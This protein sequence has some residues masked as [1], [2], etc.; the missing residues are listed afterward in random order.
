[1]CSPLLHGAGLTLCVHASRLLN[2]PATAGTMLPLEVDISSSAVTAP[3]TAE[4]CPT[5]VTAPN[6]TSTATT[7]AAIATPISAESS[8]RPGWLA[9]L[10]AHDFTATIHL[11]GI[12][13]S[14]G[15]PDPD[16]LAGCGTNCPPPDLR[17]TLVLLGTMF[18]EE[19]DLA[20][21]IGAH[22][23]GASDG[24]WVGGDDTRPGTMQPQLSLPSQ[25]P[26]STGGGGS[27]EQGGGGAIQSAA[28]AGE[29]GLS[30]VALC[31]WVAR[32]AARELLAGAAGSTRIDDTVPRAVATGCTGDSSD[33]QRGQA[34]VD[35][36]DGGADS[37][38][39]R[40]R[41]VGARRD[42]SQQ[43]YMPLPSL[44]LCAACLLPF[45]PLLWTR[46]ETL[47]IRSASPLVPF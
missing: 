7:S 22:A 26:P 4:Y 11:G 36:V 32:Q 6:T 44:P 29:W 16:A 43:V 19:A 39:K 15:F 12:L 23:S 24:M 34:D 25:H 21:I 27:G 17:E 3:V 10:I 14:A 37:R 33:G 9:P 35:G 18:R 45:P 46:E 13:A 8:T 1:M 38:P 41:M 42:A 47:S 2:P 28:E 5:I 30:W 40:P 20:G 31:R